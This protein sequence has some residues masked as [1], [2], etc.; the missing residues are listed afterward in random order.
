MRRCCADRNTHF[1][2]VAMG[3]SAALNTPANARQALTL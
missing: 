2:I 1:E 3:L